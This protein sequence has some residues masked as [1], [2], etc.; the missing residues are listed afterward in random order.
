[1][2][3]K[4]HPVQKDFFMNYLIDIGFDKILALINTKA[5]HPSLSYW[6]FCFFSIIWMLTMIFTPVFIIY[7]VIITNCLTFIWLT[8]LKKIVICCCWF[9]N[10]KFIQLIILFI[11]SS[12][13]YLA[14]FNITFLLH[15]TCTSDLWNLGISVVTLNCSVTHFMVRNGK[16]KK[17]KSLII[18]FYLSFICLIF[19]FII[20]KL[21]FS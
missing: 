4:T 12:T 21:K 1:M 20:I 11:W 14:C 19:F 3:S 2:A 9:I 8:L 10:E 13:S 7:I 15:F 5:I 17:K 6:I 16:M 18:V